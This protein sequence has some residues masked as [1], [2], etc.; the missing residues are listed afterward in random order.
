[1]DWT[2]PLTYIA[3]LAVLGAIGRFIWATSRWTSGV[4]SNLKRVDDDRSSIQSFMAEIRDD[5]KQIFIRLPPSVTQSASPATLTDYGKKIAE[6]FGATAWAEELA[7]R[8]VYK[9]AGKAA[10]EVDEFCQ[11][12]LKTGLD[13]TQASE[14]TRVA[15]EF[16]IDSQKVL[17]VLRIVLRDELLKRR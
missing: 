10:F 14:V 4:D 15:Y 9:I 11:N 6:T 1:M 3:T 7:P 13:T 16:G 12:Y 8:I 5:I 2:N 17:N